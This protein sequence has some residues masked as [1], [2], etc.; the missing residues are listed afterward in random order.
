MRLVIQ[1]IKDMYKLIDAYKDI[2][3]EIHATEEEKRRELENNWN[4]LLRKSNNKFDM[5]I[6][7]ESHIKEQLLGNIKKFKEKIVSFR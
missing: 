3:I 5:I 4:E 7:T 1:P 2:N 6:H